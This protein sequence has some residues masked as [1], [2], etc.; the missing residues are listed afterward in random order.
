M[1]RLQVLLW[2]SEAPGI[3]LKMETMRRG[4]RFF[5]SYIFS[6]IPWVL[7][8]DHTLSSK[9]V[10]QWVSNISVQQ[11]HLRDR[12]LGPLTKVSDSAS[13]ERGLAICISKRSWRNADTAMWHY[14]QSTTSCFDNRSERHWT[15][16]KRQAAT[17]GREFVDISAFILL[18][19]IGVPVYSHSN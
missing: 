17:E 11:D 2:A 9:V 3:W 18:L 8:A 7:T 1:T 4:S 13:L 16:T 5:I 15:M 10:H 12:F 19:V 6:M 14:A